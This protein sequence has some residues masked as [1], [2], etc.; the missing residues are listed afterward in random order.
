[1]CVDPIG[2][3][4]TVKSLVILHFWDQHA[5]MLCINMLVILTP[6]DFCKHNH[7]IVKFMAPFAQDRKKHYFLKKTKESARVET[8]TFQKKVKKNIF[9]LRVFMTNIV[10]LCNTLRRFVTRFINLI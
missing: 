10:M 4:M 6:Y 9:M 7:I 1:M 2:A 3:K 8:K 5:Y